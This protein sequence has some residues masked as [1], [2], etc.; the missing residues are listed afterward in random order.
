MLFAVGFLTALLPQTL[1]AQ[2]VTDTLAVAGN[3]ETCQKRI[4]KAARSAGA[5]TAVWDINTH[6]LV[7]TYDT[8]KTSEQKIEQ[9]IASA[10]HD[11]PRETAPESVYKR[12]PACCQCERKKQ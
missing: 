12:L 9:K 8:A 10:G 1:S 3:C 7:V 2:T 5:A 6:L 4:E 11:T